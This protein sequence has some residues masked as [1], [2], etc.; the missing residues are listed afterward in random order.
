ML[1]KNGTRVEV[2]PTG[3][4]ITL[5][6]GEIVEGAP[7]DTD[8]YRATAQRLGYGVGPDAALECC[9][10]HDPLHA[11]VSAV[12]GFPGGSFSLRDAA[13]MLPEELR[14]LACLEEDLVLRA[15]KL[16][17]LAKGHLVLTP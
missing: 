8:A 12:L 6:T 1:L 14:E 9:R 3:S 7:H 13:G 17:S 10:D 4:R 5:P 11:I 15:Q 2:L 16:M